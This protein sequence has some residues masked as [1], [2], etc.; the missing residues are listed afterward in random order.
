MEEEAL[1]AT[2]Q[3]NEHG[4]NFP[5]EGDELMTSPVSTK[6]NGS[7]TS[8]KPTPTSKSGSD[9]S[10]VGSVAGKQSC[11][12]S[13]ICDEEVIG[14]VDEG[15]IQP[16]SDPQPNPQRAD[17]VSG[18]DHTAEPAAVDLTGPSPARDELSS[19]NI[20]KYELTLAL[21]EIAL[22]RGRAISQTPRPSHVS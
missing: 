14:S 6:T 1:V 4:T 19:Q 9:K 20:R 15:G 11:N 22:V 7:S 12:E 18:G 13:V 17:Q 16:D 10:Y 5:Q 8:G 2:G 21:R 3:I